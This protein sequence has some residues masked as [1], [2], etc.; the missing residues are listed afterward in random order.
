MQCWDSSFS[1]AV[2]HS[3][4]GCPTGVLCQ[5]PLT[6]SIFSWTNWHRHGNTLL[7][8]GIFFSAFDKTTALQYWISSLNLVQGP[9][10]LVHYSSLNWDKSCNSRLSCNSNWS[11]CWNRRIECNKYL[12]I[13]EKSKPLSSVLHVRGKCR[14][15]Q[16][17]TCCPCISDVLSNCFIYCFEFVNVE[18]CLWDWRQISSNFFFLLIKYTLWLFV[19]QSMG[20]LWPSAKVRLSV[21]YLLYKHIIS[22]SVCSDKFAL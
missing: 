12:H 5:K 16:R 14:N 11:C 13:L 6:A 17:E 3:V 9:G 18:A 20:H 2:N 22:N 4:T 8:M 1:G 7:Y 10:V 15:S 21:C 19:P